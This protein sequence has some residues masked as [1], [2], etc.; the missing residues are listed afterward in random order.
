M[1]VG[2]SD[3]IELN[4]ALGRARDLLLEFRRM[5]VGEPV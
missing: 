3:L 2:L 1:V 5:Q 4:E